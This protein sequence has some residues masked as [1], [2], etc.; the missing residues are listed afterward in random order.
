MF[1]RFILINCPGIGVG[2]IRNTSS[3][4]HSLEKILKYAFKK[5]L[6]LN[7]SGL[8]TIGLDAFVKYAGP[9]ARK[10]ST[11]AQ[12]AAKTIHGLD[13]F[14]AYIELGGGSKDSMPIWGNLN[15]VNLISICNDETLLPTSEF[16]EVQS[17]GE[18]CEAVLDCIKAPLVRNELIVA[19]LGDYREAAIDKNPTF[20][21]ACLSQFSKLIEEC[22]KD[23]GA[24]DA[25]L[26]LSTTA[27]D[28]SVEPLDELVTNNFRNELLPMFFYTP[29]GK[30][31]DLGLRLLCDIGPSIAEFF[32]LDRS[33]LEGA[34]M[35]KWF[36]HDSNP[37]I[38]QDSSL[39]S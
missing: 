7:L 3:N 33:E 9:V 36:Y 32:D 2:N 20:A 10:V 26:A 22:I 28:A 8:E 16:I 5:D 15:D 17:D 38:E 39:H 29:T 1:K 37:Q 14:E 24:D 30:T 34:S 12:L 18:A 27:I 6:K 25:L 4:D 19:T 11:T 21:T 13:D 23:I 35:G 31:F